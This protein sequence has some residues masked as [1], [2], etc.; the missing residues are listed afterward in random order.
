MEVR[1][2][3]RAGGGRGGRKKGKEKKERGGEAMKI[4]RRKLRDIMR[5]VDICRRVKGS[6]RT[7]MC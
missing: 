7:R 6:G 5:C 2:T 3:M 4:S 1:K